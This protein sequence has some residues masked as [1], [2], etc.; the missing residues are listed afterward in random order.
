MIAIRSGFG[1]IGTTGGL[2]IGGVL[3]SLVGIKEAFFIAGLVGVGL[4]LIIYLPHRVMAQRRGRTAWSEA[5]A[6]GARRRHAR[7]AADAARFE[8]VVYGRNVGPVTGAAVAGLT[9]AS[10]TDEE[11]A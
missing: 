10:P 5:I 3:G 6:S 9:V 1:Q 8:G 7:A 4:T 2:L 11:D